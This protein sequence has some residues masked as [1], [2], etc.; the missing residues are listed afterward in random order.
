MKESIVLFI[1]I[2][3]TYIVWDLFKQ[4]SDKFK[5]LNRKV[6]DLLLNQEIPA[7]QFCIYIQF[8]KYLFRVCFLFLF[9]LVY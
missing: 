7:D 6:I 8:L 3:L 1:H 2:L 4:D 9:Q 5:L